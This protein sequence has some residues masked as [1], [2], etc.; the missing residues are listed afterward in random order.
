MP[1]GVQTQIT[2]K[3]ALEYLRQVE[4]QLYSMAVEAEIS[5]LDFQKQLDFFSARLSFTAL[6]GLLNASLMRDI[7]E[8]LQAQA[9][10]IKA[11][12]DDLKGSLEK[13]EGAVQWAKVVNGITSTIAKVVSL[14]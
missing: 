13:L 6:I 10:S 11:G 3:A 9:H 5:K 8:D 14:F 7:R 2:K 4:I 1:N 12:I